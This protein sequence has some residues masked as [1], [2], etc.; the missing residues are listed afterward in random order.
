[1]CASRSSLTASPPATR[2]LLGLR[3]TATGLVAALALSGCA[4]TGPEPVED[5][6]E[7]LAQALSSGNFEDVTFASGDRESLTEAAE[8]LHEPFD[9]V[10]PEVS[11]GEVEV[12][13]PPEESPRPVTAKVQFEHV[14]DLDEIGIEEDDWTY[15]TEADLVYD[16]DASSWNFEGDAEALL[17]DYTGQEDVGMVRVA[18]DRGRIMDGN[19][20]AMVYNRDVVR[21]GIDKSELDADDDD[22]VSSA[23]RQ[24]ADVVEIDPD[25]YAAQV[26]DFG[27][28][29][30]VE[31]I[32]HRTDS[33]SI[34]AGDI[35][36]IPGAVAREDTLPLA[37][38]P[39]FAPLLLGRVGP[40]TAE[41]L[42][43][44][45]D[46]VVGD[47]VGT[48][49]L[50]AAYESTLR[51][52]PGVS[53]HMNGETLFSVESES[54]DDI[55]TTLIPGL[56][57][58][59]QDIVDDQDT[60]ASIV[61]IRPS[62]G[63]IMAA[64]S[65]SPDDSFVE[66]G[67]QAMYA[68]GST[69]KVVSALAMLREG[70]S[71]DDTVNCPN[72]T[73]VH[74]Q[75]FGNYDGFPQEYLGNIPFRDAV[76]VSCNTVFANAYDDVTSAQ[77]QEASRDLGMVPEPHIGLPAVMGTVPDDS[78]QNLHAANLF[79]QGV[80]E[81]SVLGMATV[82]ASIGAGETV[83]P[84]LVDPDDMNDDDAEAAAE[85]A[86]ENG[87]TSD[88][89]SD[90]RTLMTDTVNFGSLEDMDD[91]PGE[92]V[93]AKTGTAEVGP[94]DDL[95]SHT[96]AIALHGDLAVAVFLEEGEFGGSTNGPLLHDFLT[97]AHD[98]L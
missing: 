47:T 78:E 17:P 36:E 95:S 80:V 32:V 46:L 29:A 84:H 19:D 81:S 65:H 89:A 43:D 73:V 1:M 11:L 14:W 85:D 2:R 69:F 21:I 42:E 82:M 5:T 48:S 8:K 57:D 28:E 87:I 90:L 31:A 76:A 27:D 52:E 38:S 10:T 25:D 45:P 50:Q 60:T 55:A 79:G 53:I 92:Q 18:A 22:A 66:T 37:D 61:A 26:L 12:D 7:T 51:G 74:G 24:L 56:Q 88:E 9:G 33:D 34:T 64:A 75:G 15:T 63:S 98:I 35:A 16:E 71:P 94:E 97:A 3:L 70:T 39:D 41:N 49:G 30:F 68:P 20:R 13:E 54:G 91:V 58:A 83:H 72:Q 93:F 44:D 77:L 86:E 6:A 23:A 96:W 59:A 4:D 40:V 67:T 62:D